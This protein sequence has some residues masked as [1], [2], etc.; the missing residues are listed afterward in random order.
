MRPACFAILCGLMLISAP[1]YAELPGAPK[2]VAGSLLD[3]PESAS[4]LAGRW[5]ITM[6]HGNEGEP[7]Q[8]ELVIS[9]ASPGNIQGGFLGAP[10]GQSAMRAVGKTTVFYAQTDDGTGPV[11]HS[12]RLVDGVVT[13]QSYFSNRKELQIWQGRQM[14]D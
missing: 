5:S 12:G 2:P 3:A 7:T 13:G 11:Y 4:D 10:F 8:E 6:L 1:T 14:V 9:S